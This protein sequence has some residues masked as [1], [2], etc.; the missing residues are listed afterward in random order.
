MLTLFRGDTVALRES[1]VRKNKNENDVVTA[2][3]SA[4]L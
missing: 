4:S 1:V 2:V 3:I